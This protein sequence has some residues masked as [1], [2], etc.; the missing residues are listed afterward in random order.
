MKSIHSENGSLTR[1]GRSVCVYAAQWQSPIEQTD[2]VFLDWPFL[3]PPSPPSRTQRQNNHFYLRF[4]SFGVGF[5]LV[6]FFLF[7]FCL[8]KV[9]EI[10]QGIA[11]IMLS[12]EA[13][14][15]LHVLKTDMRAPGDAGVWKTCRGW[16]W[17]T[18]WSEVQNSLPL[19]GCSPWKSVFPEQEKNY[20]SSWKK[21]KLIYSKR[22]PRT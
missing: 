3:G 5:F 19:P 12:N 18:D 8:F 2:C 1:N 14:Y 16:C 20:V 17:V 6:F 7:F 21:N 9:S 11:R 4:Y 15:V 22:E 10:M 13:E